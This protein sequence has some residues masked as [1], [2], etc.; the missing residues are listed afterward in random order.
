MVSM[1][2]AIRTTKNVL[3]KHIGSL[4]RSICIPIVASQH[5][6]S[7]IVLLSS[8]TMGVPGLWKQLE[9]IEQKISLHDLAVKT[10]FVGNATGKRAFCV[11]IDASSWMCRA[12]ALPGYTESPELVTL[13][14]RCSRLFGLPFIPVFIFDG[15]A[16]PSIK[17]GKV[18]KGDD[19]WLTAS[20][21]S[22]IEGF[23]FYWFTAPGEAE[24]TLSAMTSSGIPCRIDAILTDDSDVFVFGAE[25]VL[26]IRSEDNE[27]YSA[28][29][30]SAFDIAQ[31]LNLSRPDFVLIALLAG[32]DY[33]D[34][35][36]GC[37]IAIAYGLAQAGLGQQLV[38]GLNG[39]AGADAKTF[40]DQWRVLVQRELQMNS[41]GKL[42]HRCPSLAANIPND[43]PD[44]HVI[45]LYLHPTVA[46]LECGPPIALSL[47]PP[48]LDV[49]A[50][51]AEVHFAWG[52]SVGILTHFANSLFGGLVVRGL[53]DAALTF[54]NPSPFG[55]APSII[56]SVVG[57]RTHRSTGFLAELRLVPK[58]HPDFLTVALDAIKGQRDPADGAKAAI[59]EWIKTRLPKIRAWVPRSM[60][61][62]V[63]PSLVLDYVS[64][65]G[66]KVK[67]KS[68]QGSMP[69]P[70]NPKHSAT[71]PKRYSVRN[72][73]HHG[74]EVLELVSDSDGEF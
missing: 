62:L 54:D 33:S 4:Y 71:L 46:K 74:R 11:G 5:S 27:N 36:D 24:A 51:F 39:L 37:G 56:T 42:P 22:M 66:D 70:R 65:K 52:D 3:L 26:R 29:R 72:L 43:F 47:N 18:V 6:F 55:L 13:F 53:V 14:A 30:Y 15:P 23:G 73:T 32:G 57:E 40:L 38:H 48:R 17:R 61:E 58:I 19:H 9:P 68:S 50:C 8:P 69:T 64:A 16:R 10:G 21:Q 35:L 20:F 34:G 7:S 59:A 31:Q 1:R 49:L 45:N 63:Y 2:V 12:C 41:S 44:L 25:V 67:T 60:V 28:S